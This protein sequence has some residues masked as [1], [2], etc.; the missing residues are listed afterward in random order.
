MSIF[1]SWKNFSRSDSRLLLHATAVRFQSKSLLILGPSGSGKSKLAVDMISLG[2]TLI[3]DDR[4]WLCIEDQRLCLEAPEQVSGQIEARGLGILRVKPS[5]QGPT[6]L[7]YCLDLSLESRE[8]LPFTQ[9]VTKL[10]YKILV[11]PG[12]PIVPSA[13]ALMLLLKNGFSEDE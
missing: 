13:S 11:L 4:V 6:E 5:V 12:L 10:G 1:E 8:R 9:E 3:S 2:A 7:D